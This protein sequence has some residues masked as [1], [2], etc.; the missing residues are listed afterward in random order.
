M[1]RVLDFI[2]CTLAVMDKAAFNKL[3]GEF[4]RKK[5]LEQKLSQP[6]LSY[7]MGLDYQYISRVERGLISPTLFWIYG[8]AKA[9]DMSMIQFV[10]ELSHYCRCEDSDTD[11][12][13]N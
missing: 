3:F 10:S 7:K 13:F 4:V 12:I 1:F 11:T 9:L 6:Q 8:L 2:I 5:R